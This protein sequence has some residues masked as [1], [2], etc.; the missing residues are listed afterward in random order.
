MTLSDMLAVFFAYLLGAVPFG[1]LMGK[2]KGIDIREHGSG[3]IGATNVL[4]VLGKPLGITTFVLDALKGFIPSFFFPAAAEHLGPGAMDEQVLAV[5][6]GAFAI[7]GHNFP[8]FLKFKGGKGIATSAGVLIGIAPLAALAGVITWAVVFFISRYVSLA[9]II[10]AI[11]VI[12]AGW[13][14]YGE[15]NLVLPIVLTILGLLA[16]LRHKSNITR[17][18][19]GTESR[20]ARK[21]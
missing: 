14:L 6:C 7:L 8:V 19:N 20:F 12:T 10:A 13:I 17:L 4:R 16:I 11:G 21:K 15:G 18:M 2:L 9:S 3:N 5:L 1:L